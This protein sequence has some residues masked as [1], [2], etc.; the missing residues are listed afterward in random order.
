[1]D[2]EFG[3]TE[4]VVRGGSDK[5]QTFSTDFAMYYSTTLTVRKSYSCIC[6]VFSEYAWR[7][8]CVACRESV[9][10]LLF[11][12]KNLIELYMPVDRN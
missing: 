10:D 9:F 8:R 2:D 1:M 3:Y 4:N 6:T 12:R 5:E 7:G 11:G